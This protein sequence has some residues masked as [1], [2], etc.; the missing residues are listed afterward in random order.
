MRAAI[1]TAAADAGRAAGEQYR[2]DGKPPPSVPSVMSGSL[3]ARQA[4]S[5][6]HRGFS[7]SRNAPEG[8]APELAWPA[9]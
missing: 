7:E 2:K 5:A 3:L 4:A 8:T 1:L 6:W 9:S